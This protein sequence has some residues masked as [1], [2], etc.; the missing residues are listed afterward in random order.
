[1]IDCEQSLATDD[2]AIFVERA[3]FF[4][5]SACQA[6]LFNGTGNSCIVMQARITVPTLF[7]ITDNN[8]DSDIFVPQRPQPVAGAEIFYAIEDTQLSVENNPSPLTGF[9]RC[10]F[11]LESG[12]PSGT[13]PT[14]NCIDI[15]SSIADRFDTL[16]PAALEDTL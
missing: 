1:M 2:V 16:R 11:D 12:L 14:A 3:S 15:I 4:N 9:F 8:D 10:D 6:D 13:N 5:T 7:E